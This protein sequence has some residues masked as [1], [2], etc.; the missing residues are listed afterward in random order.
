[1][2][3]VSS[4]FIA[5]TLLGCN[6]DVPLGTNNMTN[7]AGPAL[8]VVVGTHVA[9]DANGAAVLQVAAS[10]KNATTVHILLGGCPLFVQLIPD[11]SGVGIG[12]LDA[13]MACPAGSPTLDMA[14]GDS[15]VQLTELTAAMLA[16]YAPGTYSLNTA[17][18]SSTGLYGP[19]V[20]EVSLPLAPAP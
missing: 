7:G 17:V 6:R 15:T 2:R 1:M 3:S 20:I 16:S 5:F 12:N 8:T 9:A 18:T 11:P 4:L 14:P 13:S 19:P 10:F